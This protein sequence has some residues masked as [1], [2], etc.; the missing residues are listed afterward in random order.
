MPNIQQNKSSQRY[1]KRCHVKEELSKILQIDDTLKG[2]SKI[3][4][5]I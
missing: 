1:W 2:C 4:A 5:E 3:D